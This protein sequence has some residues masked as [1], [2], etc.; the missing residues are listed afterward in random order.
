[1]IHYS[2]MIGFLT[3][4]GENEALAVVNRLDIAKLNEI[5]PVFL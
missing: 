4:N 1:M 2:L 5:M 3:E